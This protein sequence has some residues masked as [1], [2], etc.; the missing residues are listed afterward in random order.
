MRLCACMSIGL[1]IIH[2]C[3]FVF[4]DRHLRRAGMDYADKAAVNHHASW[5]IFYQWAQNSGRRLVLLDTKGGKPYPAFSFQALDILVLGQ[6]SSGIPVDI[7]QAIPQSVM[8]PM[9][10]N[11]RSLNVSLA[12]AMVVGE[13]LRQLNLFPSYPSNESIKA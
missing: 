12:A 10:E 6:E 5:E 1:D 13:S 9:S 7:F 3:G 4:E 2:P 11:C 8:I